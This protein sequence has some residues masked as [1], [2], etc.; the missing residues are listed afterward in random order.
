MKFAY[1][2]ACLPY[3]IAIMLFYSVAIH[4]YNALGGWPESI[5]TRGFPETLL[6]HINIQ[7]VYL[8]YLLGFTVFIIPIIIIICSFVKKWRFLIKYLSIQIIGLIIFFLQM[9]FAPD[10]YVYWFWD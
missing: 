5:G 4:I 10:E 6:F 1:S 9:F 8:S 3:T 2:L 7:N